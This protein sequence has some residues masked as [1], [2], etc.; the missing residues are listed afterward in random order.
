[1]YGAVRSCECCSA[2]MMN[3]LGGGKNT[4]NTLDFQKFMIV[5]VG[6]FSVAESLQMCTG[7][8]I[9]AMKVALCLIWFLMRKH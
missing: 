2:T 8:P 9:S 3:I 4:A 7:V 6:E 5:P 1:M